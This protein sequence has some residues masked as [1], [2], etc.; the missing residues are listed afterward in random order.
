MLG[1]A[2]KCAEFCYIL[3]G[4]FE[5]T[6]GTIRGIVFHGL[7]FINLKRFSSSST[8]LVTEKYFAVGR[9]K[10]DCDYD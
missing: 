10:V 4:V 3:L 9:K 6:R 7:E 2:H 5:I 1:L 8:A